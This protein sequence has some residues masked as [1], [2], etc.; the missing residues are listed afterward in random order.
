MRMDVLHQ[1]VLASYYQEGS[2]PLSVADDGFFML[3]L[4]H[5]LIGARRLQEMRDLLCSTSWLQ[6][7]MEAYGAASVVADFRRSLLSGLI[8]GCS[9]HI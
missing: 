5:H 4:G 2:S 6:T 7:K 3:H 8:F 1:R 9:N